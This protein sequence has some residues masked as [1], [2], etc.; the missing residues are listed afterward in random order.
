MKQFKRIGLVGSLSLAA[1]SAMAAVPADVTTALGDAKTD[2]LTV[3]GL[4]LVV[5][6]AIAA[7]KYM[8]KAV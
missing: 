3:A 2:S 6:I 1:G 5:I 7:F 8:R 4:A